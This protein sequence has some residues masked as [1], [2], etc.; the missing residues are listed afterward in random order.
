MHKQTPNPPLAVPH[1]STQQQHP[2]QAPLVLQLLHPSDGLPQQA[3]PRQTDVGVQAG[4]QLINVQ[5]PPA[6]AACHLL[7]PAGPATM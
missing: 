2:S 1:V 6:T 3:V 5:A 4:V 7:I